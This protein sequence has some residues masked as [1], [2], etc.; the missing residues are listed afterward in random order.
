MTDK[1]LA[2]VLFPD[3]TETVQDLERIYPMRNID[4]NAEI[5]R[6]G[7]SPTGYINMGG[8]YTAFI[9][10]KLANQSNGHFI[11]RI[12]DNNQRDI[13]D[14]G[15]SDFVN[16]LVSYGIEFDEGYFN[17]KEQLGEYGPYVQTQRKRIYQIVVKELVEKG[18]AYPCFCTAD[19]LENMPEIQKER[20]VLTGYYGKY[21]KCKNLSNEEA[22]R[23]VRKGE[24][25]VIRIKSEKLLKFKMEYYI[26]AIK[27][28]VKL[29]PSPI[30]IVILKTS[31]VPDYNFAHVV[32]DH[33]MR[34]TVIT[35]C[36]DWLPS[37]HTHLALFYLTGWI[38][39]QY[40]HIGAISIKL[41]ERSI[42]K[43]SKK[44]GEKVTVDYYL[45]KG[46]ITK[47][48]HEYFMMIACA[49]YEEY[50]RGN[51]KGDFKFSLKK[52]SSHGAILDNDK[53]NY[54]AR[55]EMSNLSIMELYNQFIKWMHRFHPDKVEQYSANY[56]FTIKILSLA[57][58]LEK[59]R[60]AVA[61][62]DDVLQETEKFFH[63]PYRGSL[64]EKDRINIEVYRSY[65]HISF[66][67]TNE[68]KEF[69]L[70][71]NEAH[72][73][74]MSEMCSSFRKLFTGEDKSSSV[75]EMLI[76]FNDM[77]KKWN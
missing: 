29:T 57:R 70:Q 39:P 1:E 42:V 74:S 65:N 20:H 14:E 58:G 6:F 40:A 43:V 38:P 44:L 17:E 48:I 32:D 4:E 51:K 28:K 13:I 9:S 73:I 71:I 63:M 37:L 62:F 31:G 46:Y 69:L 23:K 8:L 7:A 12:E 26:D 11:L 64:D 15:I 16:A 34:T 66:N 50:W 21:A 24:P 53:L 52:M 61:C 55:M 67:T 41:N 76:A 68:V 49:E 60:K 3:I 35:R 77:I 2:N 18:M 22:A 25:F 45:K 47:A 56:V 59:E 19:M 36:E 33:F 30:D 72:G 75:L 54:V 5:T 27:G 10:W